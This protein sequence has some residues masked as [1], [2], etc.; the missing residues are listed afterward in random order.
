MQAAAKSKD[1]LLRRGGAWCREGGS[2]PYSCAPGS[3]GR[4]TSSEKHT[5]LPI[6][7]EESRASAERILYY[8]R[9]L[10][11]LEAQPCCKCLQIGKP[12]VQ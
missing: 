9:I 12:S 2:G 4:G 11:Y 5:S 8:T 6:W 1:L 3:L 7:W 10:F